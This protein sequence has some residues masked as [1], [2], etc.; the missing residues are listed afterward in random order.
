MRRSDSLSKQIRRVCRSR[1]NSVCVCIRYYKF[2]ESRLSRT[3]GLV[4]QSVECVSYEP[5]V[6]GS[7]PV[8]TIYIHTVAI[9]DTFSI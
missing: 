5:V 6:T 1:P 4:A 8:E 7:N 9:V 3:K 2:N